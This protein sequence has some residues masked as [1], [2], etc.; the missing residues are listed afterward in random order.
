MEQLR[1]K[2]ERTDLSDLNSPYLPKTFTQ[3][4]REAYGGVSLPFIREV[5]E[6]L[7][8]R[9]LDQVTSKYYQ[10][11][12]TSPIYSQNLGLSLQDLNACAEFQRLSS[13]LARWSAELELATDLLD[14]AQLYGLYQPTSSLPL[15]FSSLQ[16]EWSSGAEPGLK[17]MQRFLLQAMGFMAERTAS[18]IRTY[19]VGV[20][21]GN[22]DRSRNM[23]I[24]GTVYAY[25]CGSVPW[26]VLAILGTQTVWVVSGWLL[27]KASKGLGQGFDL[28][29]IE[30]HLTQLSDQFAV[31]TSQ[32]ND[33]NE[34]ARTDIR[35]CV[36][37]ATPQDRVPLI[38]NL[39][40]TL[41]SF[42]LKRVE[43]ERDQRS[44]RADEAAADYLEVQ[45]LEDWLVIDAA[46]PEV[47]QLTKSLFTIDTDA[48]RS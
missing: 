25:L 4:R 46:D 13:I 9:F 26:A 34:R 44:F 12:S 38:Q 17:K 27:M 14:R 41:E 21:A 6:G 47:V 37:A 11:I 40:R 19:V 39:A 7:L 36:S 42:L 20:V 28:K 30:I 22:M 43:I 16:K 8:P 32:L 15:S 10:D 5:D 33:L 18:F 23:I 48:H 24:A 31:L 45:E 1:E 3:W 2:C 35:A 29:Q